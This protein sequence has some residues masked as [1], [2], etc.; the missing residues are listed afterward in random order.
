MA[1]RDIK[2]LA[3]KALHNAMQVPALA[4]T[5]GPAGPSEAVRMRVNS[6]IANAGDLAGTSLAY[7]E[8]VETNPHLI[9]LVAE[10]VPERGNVY[11][12][13]L[14]EAYRVDHTEPTDTITITAICN[15]LTEE[16]AAEFTP[17][18]I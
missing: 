14:D 8:S 10:H 3:R 13:A 18:G 12:V 4:Y 9:F 11:S 15:R 6:K 16:E 17:P 2:T 5:D 7:A 1:F